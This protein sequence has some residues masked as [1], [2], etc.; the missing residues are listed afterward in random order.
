M[1]KG[2]NKINS[3]LLF[4]MIYSCSNKRF[5]CEGFNFERL[6]YDSSYFYKDLYYTNGLDTIKLSKVDSEFDKVSTY[7]HGIYYNDC[8]PRFS[9]NLKDLHEKFRID[10]FFGY[11]P[12]EEDK[13]LLSLHI[14]FCNFKL[15]LDSIKMNST[16]NISLGKAE[17]YSVRLDSSEWVKNVQLEKLRITMIEKYSGEKWHL[18]KEDQN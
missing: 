3:L 18:I 5:P 8:Y 9:I 16:T 7:V 13:L 11:Y 4:A 12:T 14:N 17:N 2:L 1:I 6:P 15:S 10:Y